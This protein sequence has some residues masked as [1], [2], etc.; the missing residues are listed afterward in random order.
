MKKYTLI[1]GS[2]LLAIA[3]VYFF[4]FRSHAQ[5]YSS[6]SPG[7]AMTSS[8]I[9]GGLLLAGASTSTTVTMAGAA[10][11]MTVV[12]TPN[13]Y[14]GDGVTWYAYVSS[15]NTVTIKACAIIAITP[16]SSTY[17]VRLFH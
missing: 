6:T 13:T 5:S 17:N 16:N 1:F 15:A 14:P 10:M 2:L 8:S 3:G 4:G 11:G 9:G 7:N 12:A